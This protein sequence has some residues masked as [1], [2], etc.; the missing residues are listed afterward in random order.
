MLWLGVTT[1]VS[2]RKGVISAKV[3]QFNLFC[4]NYTSRTKNN[5]RQKLLLSIHSG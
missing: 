5:S 3:D 2:N 4:K 1:T